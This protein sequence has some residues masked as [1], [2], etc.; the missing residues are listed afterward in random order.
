M[1]TEYEF[2]EAIETDQVA[3][4]KS[5]KQSW[6]GKIIEKMQNLDATFPLSGGEN[7]HPRVMARN[8]RD[9]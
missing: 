6:F 5:P 3:K 9:V 4:Q 1:V 2:S 8:P 7:D